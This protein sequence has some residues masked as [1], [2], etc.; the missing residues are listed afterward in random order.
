MAQRTLIVPFF[1]VFYFEHFD[2]KLDNEE[3]NYEHIFLPWK[4]QQ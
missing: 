4:R 1:L 2:L 3:E